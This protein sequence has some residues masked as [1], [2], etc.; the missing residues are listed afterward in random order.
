MIIR[1]ATTFMSDNAN[2]NLVVSGKIT[3]K[4]GE[5]L[6]YK[7]IDGITYKLSKDEVARLQRFNFTPRY[8]KDYK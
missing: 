4:Y 3:G 7:T 6:E 8:R 5:G 1:S 2:G